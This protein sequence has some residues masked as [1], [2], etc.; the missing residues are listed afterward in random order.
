MQSS[1]I[2]ATGR[3]EVYLKNDFIEQSQIGKIA[4][5]CAFAIT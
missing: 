4:G 5:D 3:L 1:R 2:A